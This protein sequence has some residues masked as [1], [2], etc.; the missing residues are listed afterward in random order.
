MAR[1]VNGN[2]A[3]KNISSSVFSPLEAKARQA[4]GDFYP[5]HTG[6]TF[7]NPPAGAQMWD[8]ETYRRFPDIH[9]YSAFRGRT[10]LVNAIKEARILR[11]G[12]EPESGQ[13]I[14][15]VGATGALAA[16]VRALLEPGQKMMVL[17]PYWP[18]IRGLTISHDVEIIEVPFYDRGYDGHAT[19]DILE[20]HAGSELA[21]IYL[22]WPNNPTGYVPTQEV[23]EQIADFACRNDLWV[24]SDEVYEDYI[25]STEECPRMFDL[26][27]MDNRLL[28]VF[29][30]SK[31]YGMAGNR[32]GYLLGCSQAVDYI[33]GMTTHLVVAPPNGGQIAA[34]SAI[35]NGSQWLSEAREMYRRMAQTAA[36]I[37][38]VKTPMGGTFLFLD[39]SYALGERGMSGFLESCAEAG[40][41]VAPGS[42]CGS[43]YENYIRLCF[44]SLPPDET[45]NALNILAKRLA[46]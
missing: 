16:A 7:L 11:D 41:L 29:S 2:R 46:D 17:A 39:V 22:N 33:S 1:L 18:I 42:V 35:L 31:A 32:V 15:T 24:F 6:D 43:A 19:K 38:G 28:R 13:I 9:K 5:L 26:D 40:L 8:S 36:H 27:G 21:G 4:G 12:V 25:Y 34:A 44:T 23:V 10:E 3:V 14:V 37:L 45:T 30:F 20:S